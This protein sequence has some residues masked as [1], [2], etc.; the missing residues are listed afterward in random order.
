VEIR[1]RDTFEDITLLVLSM[2]EESWT[3]EFRW[4]LQADQ[5]KDTDSPL[6]SLE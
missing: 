6:E 2:V 1:V 3:K 4:S 5:G